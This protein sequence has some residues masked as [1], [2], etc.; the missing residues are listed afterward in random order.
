MAESDMAEDKPIPQIMVFRPTWDEFKDFTTY[1][2]YMET[3]G[4]HKAGLAKVIPPKE[5][6]PRKQGYDLDAIPIQ[7]PAPICQVVTGKDGLYQQIN[8]Q[9]KLMTVKQLAELAKTERFA[10]PAHENYDDLE[11]KYWNN[12]TYVAPIYGA[13]VS[14][15]LTDPECKEW[16]INQLN[17]I[18]DYVNSDY[19]IQID[20]VNTAY[21]YFGMWKTTFAWHTE[22]MDLYSI[23]YLHMGEPKTW[24]C[25]PPVYGRKL[26][27]M[28]NGYFPASHKSCN[29]YLRHKMTLISPQILKQHKIPYNKITQEAGEIMITFPYGYHSGFNHGFNCAESTNFAMERWVEYGKRALQCFCSNDMV[30]IS[31]DTFVKRFQPDKYDAWIQG[32]DI[33]PHPEDPSTVVAAAP[34]PS[35]LDILVN[36]NNTNVPTPLIQTLKKKCNPTMSKSFKERNPDLDINEIQNNPNVPDDVKAVLSGA[37]LDAPIDDEEAEDELTDAVGINDTSVEAL[38]LEKYDDLY[39]DESDDELRGSRRG[40]RNVDDDWFATAKERKEKMRKSM[41]PRPRGRPKRKSDEG[42]AVTDDTE[43]PPKIQRKVVR[44]KIK[45]E[46]KDATAENTNN[47]T[48]KSK[49]AK[50]KPPTLPFA[51]LDLSKKFE[52]KI[53]NVKQNNSVT[54]TEPSTSTSTTSSTSTV[55]TATDTRPPNQSIAAML[56]AG[57]G[58]HERK[59][60]K[61]NIWRNASTPASSATTHYV[62][63]AITYPKPHN[64]LRENGVNDGTIS[65]SSILSNGTNYFDDRTSNGDGR[66]NGAARTNDTV[67][68]QS[69]LPPPYIPPPSRPAYTPEPPAARAD[70]LSAYSKFIETSLQKSVLN[71]QMQSGDMVT[72]TP[73]NSHQQ[74]PQSQDLQHQ[75]NY[76]T[77]NNNNNNNSNVTIKKEIIVKS[78]NAPSY[79]VRMPNGSVRPLDIKS[80]NGG[81][82]YGAIIKT[83]CKPNYVPQRTY[84]GVNS[85][86]INGVVANGDIKPPLMITTTAMAAAASVASIT[87]TSPLPQISPVNYTNLNSINRTA[88]YKPK[89]LP[90]LPLQ[91]QQPQQQQ[92][93]FSHQ[94]QQ[95]QQNHH[96]QNIDPKINFVKSE[97][98]P[99]H[100]YSSPPSPYHAAIVAAA[101]SAAANQQQQQRK[102]NELSNNGPS[103]NQKHQFQ[104]NTTQ[105]QQQQQ[106]IRTAA[107]INEL[108][109]SYDTSDKTI[110]PR[111]TSPQTVNSNAF[112]PQFI[113]NQ[114][115]N[116]A[117]NNMMLG[118]TNSSSSKGNGGVGAGNNVTVQ[119]INTS[120]NLNNSNKRGVGGIP[121]NNSTP[122]YVTIP[123]NNNR[124]LGI[125]EDK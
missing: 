75:R 59:Q 10:T 21:L 124:L 122:K 48:P 44:K 100:K 112:S 81:L 86:I 117:A 90:N 62:K 52:G 1:V 15:S 40:K 11:E 125:S 7:I 110:A 26:E 120:Q 35:D 118:A 83:E 82:S 56:S 51:L 47:T 61:T 113:Y 111:P 18:L 102:V 25:V 78:E 42:I 71:K 28:A 64:L 2:A 114:Y 38:L 39:A 88:Q 76:N 31:M 30:K 121:S 107:P 63:S 91:S 16:N 80:A 103:S 65:L 55:E 5:W 14:G 92:K 98:I 27:K 57:P 36:K 119:H 29:A 24:Y 20:G 106:S 94:Q 109:Q 8:I 32:T 97:M 99:H 72:D 4:A 79:F 46:N 37:I 23:N 60:D 54:S 6:V 33:G 17:T 12:I 43:K 74:P 49:P 68:R 73:L 95:Q 50:K 115:L 13:D 9:K 66:I 116:Y 19:G 3:Q 93:P 34:T 104:T 77:N 96:N 53:P 123:A 45:Q 58:K 84:G 41:K 22:D 69:I 108:Q 87:N 89:L 85:S 70:Y 101:A 67:Q 105:Q